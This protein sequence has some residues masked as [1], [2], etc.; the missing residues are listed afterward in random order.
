MNKYIISLIILS[1]LISS[2]KSEKEGNPENIK[3]QVDAVERIV[4]RF[5]HNVQSAI[6]NNNFSY[7]K[8]VSKT[9]IDSC[10]I[11]LN[12]LK[13][14]EVPSSLDNLKNSAISYI[15]TMKEII[16]AEEQYSNLTDLTSR[17]GASIM[18]EKLIKA[19][20]K[21]KNEHTKYLK[22]LNELSSN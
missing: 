21:A 10:N 19:T 8:L 11:K 20:E 2:C 6:D 4:N 18:D 3:A 16:S 17:L 1:F 14:V 7:I 5:D 9:A 15:M 13:S 22:L 12:E